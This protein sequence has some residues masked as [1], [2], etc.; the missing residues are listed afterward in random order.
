MVVA[1]AQPVDERDLGQRADGPGDH[2][3]DLAV[4]GVRLGGELGAAADLGAVAERD[5]QH[6]GVEVVDD[7][8][9]DLDPQPDL[10]RVEGGQHGP[11]RVA[12][13]AQV[14]LAVADGAEPLLPP[15]TLPAGLGAGAHVHVV[16]HDLAELVDEQVDRSRLAVEDQPGRLGDVERDVVAAGEVVAGAERQQAD[17]A[18]GQLVA[19]V[20]RRDHRV[21]AAV[22]AGHDDASGTGTVQDAVQL[23]GAR[24][25]GDLDGGAGAQHLEGCLEVLLVGRPG[26]AVG[27]DEEWV[28]G[29]NPSGWVLVAWGRKSPRQRL[30]CCPGLFLFTGEVW[31]ARNRDPRSPVG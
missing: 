22:A 21:H 1:A 8:V 3:V 13:L 10:R 11:D 20:E 16:D 19:A 30:S 17:D 28:H 24:G 23:A 5:H 26:V 15:V 31:H 4:L 2:H 12:E 18:S 29:R 9:V 25:G 6:R 27:D 7:R 14:H